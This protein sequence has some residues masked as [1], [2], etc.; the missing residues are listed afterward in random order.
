MNNWGNFFEELASKL[1]VSDL[2]I[3]RRL[4]DIRDRNNKWREWLALYRTRSL[5]YSDDFACNEISLEESQ[6]SDKQQRSLKPH[7]MQQ[8]ALRGHGQFN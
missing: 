4:A 5:T 7:T 8:S 2:A 6:Q 1:G 3:E